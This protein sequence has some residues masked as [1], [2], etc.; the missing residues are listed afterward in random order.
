MVPCDEVLWDILRSFQRITVRSISVPPGDVASVPVVALKS[1]MWSTTY[2][3]GDIA[4]LLKLSE[5]IFVCCCCVVCVSLLNELGVCPVSE[6]CFLSPEA[7]M[8]LFID[9]M[10][11]TPSSSITTMCDWT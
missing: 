1:Y 7:A 4:I 5:V 3:D 6:R 9:T 10:F 8:T 2:S 11:G